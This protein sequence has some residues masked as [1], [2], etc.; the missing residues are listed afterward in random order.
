MS[1]L[2]LTGGP[3]GLCCRVFDMLGFVQN[4]QMK[5]LFDENFEI[6]MQQRIGSH[7]DV[8]LFHL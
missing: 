3:G 4:Q 6:A 8:A 2:Q 1:R 7:D 5:F